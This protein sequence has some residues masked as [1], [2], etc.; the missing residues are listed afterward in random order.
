[1]LLHASSGPSSTE[2]NC[3][4]GATV[5]WQPPFTVQAS[6]VCCCCDCPVLTVLSCASIPIVLDLSWRMCS[7]EGVKLRSRTVTVLGASM[8]ASLTAERVLCTTYTACGAPTQQQ[9]TQQG[10]V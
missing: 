3:S 9:H 7:S 10:F 2:N 6:K 8:S 5:H 4:K 1:M